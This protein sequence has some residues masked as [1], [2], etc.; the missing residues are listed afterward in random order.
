M[1]G[2]PKVGGSKKNY[3]T[4]PYKYECKNPPQN[5]SNMKPTEQYTDD[6]I[7]KC[8]YTRNFRLFNI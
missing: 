2:D 6:A 1:E 5:K 4:I 3:T 7:N 8:L